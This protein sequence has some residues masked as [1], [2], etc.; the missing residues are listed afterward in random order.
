MTTSQLM[1]ARPSVFDGLGEADYHAH[2]AL[3][4]TGARALLRCP[5]RFAYERDHPEEPS[6]EM[7]LG[8][9][10]HTTLLGTGQAWEIA[11]ARWQSGA[12]KDAVAAIRADGKIPLRP[13]AADKATAMVAEVRNHATASQLIKPGWGVAERSLFWTDRATGVHCRARIDWQPTALPLLVD[14]KTADDCS[15]SALPR[16]LDKRGYVI[17]AAFYLQGAEACGIA[18][19][20]TGFTFV[21]VESRPPHLVTVVDPDPDDLEWAMRQCDKAREIFRDCTE[22]GTWPGYPQHQTVRLPPW[23]RRDIEPEEF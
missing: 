16:L 11:P 17:Q 6:E 13:A 14:L 12:E 10:V 2:A 9:A 18:D 8:S 5:A 1:P 22:A 19:A 23:A 20:S 4:S 15:P 7:E 21:F 3:S